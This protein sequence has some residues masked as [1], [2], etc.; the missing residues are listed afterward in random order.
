MHRLKYATDISEEVA[1]ITKVDPS[2]KVKEFFQAP[3]FEALENQKESIRI[4]DDVH[5]LRDV[6]KIAAS[7]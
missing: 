7:F 3:F 4:F 2:I 5:E 6:F 1:R